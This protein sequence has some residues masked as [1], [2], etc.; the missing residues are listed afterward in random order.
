MRQVDRR[1]ETC[2]E[3]RRPTPSIGPIIDSISQSDWVTRPEFAIRWVMTGQRRSRSGDKKWSQGRIGDP[4]LAAPS[5]SHRAREL[6]GL[7]I[8]ALNESETRGPVDQLLKRI[9]D[10]VLAAAMLVLASP[11]FL[12]IAIAIKFNSR[13]DILFRQIRVGRSAKRFTLLKFRSMRDPAADAVESFTPGDSERV[14][15]IGRVLRRTKLDE[16]PQLWN[17]LIGDMS[18]VGPRPEV[19]EWTNVYPERWRIAL[20]VRPGLTD[21]ASIEF[22][23]EETMLAEAEDPKAVYRDVILPKKLQL[24]DAYVRRRT[25]A[26][27]L[28]IMARTAWIVIRPS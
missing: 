6:C 25:L 8:S 26:G 28:K 10:L 5:F 3:F 12:A 7:Y 13:G 21:P 4:A 16:L 23:N 14:T 15:S 24:A 22:R 18:L 1:N 2:H 9:F 17:I 27:D 20:S 11:L 19:P